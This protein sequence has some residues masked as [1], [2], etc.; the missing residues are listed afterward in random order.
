MNKH[1][2]IYLYTF[3]HSGMTFFTVIGTI[4]SFCVD[5]HSELADNGTFS[6]LSSV[7]SRHVAIHTVAF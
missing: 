4:P 6:R 1:S 3:I 7:S 5:I 2:H